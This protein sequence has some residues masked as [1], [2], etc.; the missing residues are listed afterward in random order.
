MF[1]PKKASLR[2]IFLQLCQSDA[3]FDNFSFRKSKN[4]NFRA[5][6]DYFTLINCC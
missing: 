3:V 4:L 6:I 5:L 2:Y 1:V